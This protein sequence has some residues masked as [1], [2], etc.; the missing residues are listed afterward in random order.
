MYQKN[1]ETTEL[2]ELNNTKNDVKTAEKIRMV[3]VRLILIASITILVIWVG[4]GFIGN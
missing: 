2:K 1:K 4:V 3:Q